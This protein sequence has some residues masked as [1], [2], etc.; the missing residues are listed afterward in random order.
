MTGWRDLVIAEEIG[1]TVAR[2][3]PK[4][5]E[6]PKTEGREENFE[7]NVEGRELIAAIPTK[8]C[9]S[10]TLW[11]DGPDPVYYFINEYDPDSEKA[12]IQAGE[13][14]RGDFERPVIERVIFRCEDGET[15]SVR[16]KLLR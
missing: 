12:P 7:V 3:M 15:A 4:P 13:N 5:E 16:L 9:F 8:P 11:N 1:A 6:K 10:Y 2:E 14:A